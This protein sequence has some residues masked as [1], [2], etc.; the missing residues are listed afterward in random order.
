MKDLQF[1]LW[2]TKPPQAQS[3]SPRSNHKAFPHDRLRRYPRLRV[4]FIG[5]VLITRE[6]LGSRAGAIAGNSRL[7]ALGVLGS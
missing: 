6:M 5:L 1:E 3:M 7:L 2:Q 4:L